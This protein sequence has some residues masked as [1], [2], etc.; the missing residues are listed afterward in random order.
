MPLGAK[1][2]GYK[3][4]TLVVSWQ[5]SWRIKFVWDYFNAYWEWSVLVRQD[6][7]EGLNRLRDFCVTLSRTYWY[8]WLF[9]CSERQR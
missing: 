2:G 1:L 8:L 9:D 3:L 7:G 6:A 5:P 4:N